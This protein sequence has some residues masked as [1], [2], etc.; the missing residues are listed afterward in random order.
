VHLRFVAADFNGGRTM[1][2]RRVMLTLAAVAVAAQFRWRHA[3]LQLAGRPP[4]GYAHAM[5]HLLLFRHTK[6]ERTQPGSTDHARAL[7][8]SGRKDSAAMGKAVAKNGPVDLVL[9]SD[10]LRA[11]ETWEMASQALDSR[12]E[13]KLTRAIYDADDYV[14]ILNT[15]G[16]DAK[17]ILLVG[18]NPAMQETAV[19]L[20]EDLSGPN[21][22]MLSSR[23][24]K[25]ALA[26][27]DFEGDWATLSPG[28]AWLVDFV[29]PERD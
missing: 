1:N 13:V 9:C 20:V 2:A 18:H 5:P 16:G 11:R 21:G 22:T 4:P 3:A 8:K 28:Q 23:F 6:A 14:P 15:E 12:P 17:T 19:S 25:A 24:P 7:T 27:L 29:I 10:A 26:V